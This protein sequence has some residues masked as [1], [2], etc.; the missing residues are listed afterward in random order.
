MPQVD[1]VLAS[2]IICQPEDAFAAARTIA[3]ALK[4]G[5]TA[6]MVSADSKHRFGVE[7]FEAA[8]QQVGC[9]TLSVENVNHIYQDILSSMA[10]TSG[11][12]EGMS[13]TM[14]KMTKTELQ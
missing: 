10:M 12:V 7:Q 9:L 8:C 13:L 6:V 11:F 5:G 2:D 1:V 3:C 14:Y 4:V